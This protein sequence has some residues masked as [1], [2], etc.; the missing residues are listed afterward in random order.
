MIYA[1][2]TGIA[3]SWMIL[4][5]NATASWTETWKAWGL[6][7]L[8][9]ALIAAVG[10]RLVTIIDVKLFIRDCNNE[11]KARPVNGND[12]L[13]ACQVRAASPGTILLSEGELMKIISS[14]RLVVN[15]IGWLVLALSS[16]TIVLVIGIG[17][18]HAQ[19]A[20][21]PLTPEQQAIYNI[22]M[23]HQEMSPEARALF[24]P[25][26][27]PPVKKDN[28][29]V[30]GYKSYDYSLKLDYAQ[31]YCAINKPTAK[32]PKVQRVYIKNGDIYECATKTIT[33]AGTE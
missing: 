10:L 23:P 30:R 15:A 22:L 9:A 7:F 4:V 25:N 31:R 16:L 1:L 18:L 26:Y 5:L 17:T 24:D 19:D 27:V 33:K 14:K 21:K 13:V 12:P 8:G 29:V 11:T 32:H 3:A 28:A 2:F 20:Q 6:A